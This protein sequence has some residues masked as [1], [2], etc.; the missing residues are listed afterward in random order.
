[1]HPSLAFTVTVVAACALQVSASTRSSLYEQVQRVHASAS[2]L[3]RVKGHLRAELQELK[4]AASELNKQTKELG[5]KVY[6][7]DAQVVSYCYRSGKPSTWKPCSGAT[8]AFG[9]AEAHFKAAE[10]WVADAK[11]FK[12]KDAG[13]HPGLTFVSRVKAGW[14]CTQCESPGASYPCPVQNT[15]SWDCTSTSGKKNFNDFITGQ[16][17]TDAIKINGCAAGTITSG[18]GG[19]DSTFGFGKDNQPIMC[20]RKYNEFEFIQLQC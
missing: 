4:E 16:A 8:E 20:D 5:S 12:C 1:M 9:A 10:T 15:Y 18:Q 19:Q 3:N 17:G 2:A 13:V 11:K 6:V 7:A 14:T